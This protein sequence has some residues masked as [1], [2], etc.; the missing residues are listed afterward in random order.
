MKQSSSQDEPL[1][2]VLVVDDNPSLRQMV[3]WSL[4]LN[5]FQ[6]LEMANGLEAVQWMEQAAHERTYPSLI[7]LDLVMPVMDGHAFLQWM[8]YLWVGHYPVPA[9]ILF[10]ADTVDEE[11]LV[12]FPTLI[13][14]IVSK[15]FH[16]RDLMDIVQKW[17]A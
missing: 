13:K 2:I 5:G 6:P 17:S 14:Q 12:F 3:A 15:P 11:V 1:P 9:I 10:T 16:A 8:Q 7:L 4:Q